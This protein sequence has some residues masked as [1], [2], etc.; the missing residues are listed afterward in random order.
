L[1]GAP[2]PDGALGYSDVRDAWNYYLRHDNRGRGVVLVGHSQGAGVLTSLLAQEIEGKPASAQLVSALLIGGDV[3][4]LKGKDVGGTFK[5]TPLCRAVSQSGCVIAFGSFRSTMPPPAHTLYGKF[6]DQALEA[7]CTNPAALAGGSG[8]LKAY[9]PT[10]GFKLLGTEPPQPPWVTPEVKINTSFVAVPGLL[11]ARCASNEHAKYLEITVNGNASDPRTDDI[12]G[13][14]GKTPL[15]A[16][17][18]LHLI[19]VN[20]TMGNLI[21]IIG[22][23]SKAYR[24]KR[25]K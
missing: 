7:G 19:D 15:A 25:Q 16:A 24:A 17:L 5:S 10:E 18:G 20:L 11:T 4:V 13:D 2:E 6:S 12:A 21:D 3:S 23:Q 14:L 1:A 9:L 22:Q 8:E